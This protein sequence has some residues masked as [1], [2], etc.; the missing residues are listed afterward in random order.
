M[1]L[2]GMEFS[3][4]SISE[5][6]NEIL[7]SSIPYDHGPRLVFTANV[8]HIVQMRR[9]PE[10]RMAYGRA[11]FRTIDGFPVYMVARIAGLRPIR[12][13]GA[14]LFATVMR[15]LDSR[16]HRCFFVVSSAAVGDGLIQHLLSRGFQKDSIEVCIPQYGFELDTW[17]STALA[18]QIVS[19]RTT[20][21]FLGVGAPKSEIWS[22]KYAERLG[23]CYVLCVG[24]GPEFF[25]GLKRRAPSL[26]QRYGFEW[27][28]RFGHEPRRLF[29]RYFVDSWGFLLAIA[30]DQWSNA[31]ALRPGNSSDVEAPPR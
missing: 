31:K 19:H 16:L 26:W 28:W 18:S 1:R 22:Y 9:R 27:L 3:N 29:R 10:F 30:E 11:W 20:H 6:S 13:T 21:L 14:D 24:A 8:D 2:F 7:L 17:F 5:L 25:L 23:N 4:K 15:G 12:V